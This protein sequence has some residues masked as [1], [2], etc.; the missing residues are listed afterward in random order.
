MQLPRVVQVR[1]EEKKKRKVEQV[2]HLKIDI[3]WHYEYGNEAGRGSRRAEHADVT[4]R[5]VRSK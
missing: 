4:L 5:G 1:A 3:R 2:W